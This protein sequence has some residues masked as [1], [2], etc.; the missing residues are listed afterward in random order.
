MTLLTNIFEPVLMDR[1]NIPNNGSAVTSVKKN[2]H[3]PARRFAALSE[4][5]KELTILVADGLTSTQ[6]AKKMHI[7]QATV[8]KHRNNILCKLNAANMTK[9]V[10]IALRSGWIE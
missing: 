5:E 7:S 8:Q 2:G 9:V 1:Q 10:A 4:R 3:T 6:I